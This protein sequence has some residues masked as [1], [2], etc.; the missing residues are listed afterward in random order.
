MT[1]FQ[2]LEEEN[3]IKI[4]MVEQS[5]SIG[6]NIILRNVQYQDVNYSLNKSKIMKVKDLRLDV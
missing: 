3:E 2:K 1:T 6:I 5:F 4:D